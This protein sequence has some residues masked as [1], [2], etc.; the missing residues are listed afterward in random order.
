MEIVVE[1]LFAVYVNSPVAQITPG[2]FLT[3][4]LQDTF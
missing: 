2:N 3:G 1:T 4:L